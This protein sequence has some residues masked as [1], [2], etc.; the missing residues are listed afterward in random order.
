[1]KY[2]RSIGFGNATLSIFEVGKMAMKLSEFIKKDTALPKDIELDSMVTFPLY[3]A[4]IALGKSSIVVDPCDYDAV[5]P[6]GDSFRP[7][8]YVAPQTLID[9]MVDNGLQPDKVSHVIIT[10]CHLDHCIGSTQL[11]EGKYVPTFPNARYYL[12]EADWNW[13]ETQADLRN[14]PEVKNSLGVLSSSKLLTLVSQEVE[15]MS[16]VTI[17]PMPGESP[18][19]QILRV[20]SNGETLY[21]VGD[22]FHTAMD[23]ADP[24]IM[25]EFNEYEVNLR[26]RIYFL[27]KAFLENSMVFCGHMS[28]GRIEKMNG[29]EFKWQAI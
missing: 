3:N 23:V 14:V 29:G 1:M 20:V 17:L 22:L 18:G 26:S 5:C 13:S 6:I 28:L 24:K 11:K 10:H 27:E 7:Q 21:C 12:G 19:H 2:S 15:I 9:Q 25:A 16:G 4:H 8:G